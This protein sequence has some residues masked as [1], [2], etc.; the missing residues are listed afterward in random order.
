MRARISA[1]KEP[2]YFFNL[3]LKHFCDRK[4]FKNI[5]FLILYKT[6]K[7]AFLMIFQAEGSM[8]GSWGEWGECSTSCGLGQRCKYF[9]SEIYTSGIP[10]CEPCDTGFEC[11]EGY[12][13]WSE[14]GPCC[15]YDA[16]SAGQ[17]RVRDCFDKMA[18]GT[19]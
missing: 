11:G 19:K 15:P 9:T 1:A 8:I 12:G 5:N 13:P 10:S 17:A 16:A 18:G 4:I 7:L 14:W 3:L 2:F 6:M